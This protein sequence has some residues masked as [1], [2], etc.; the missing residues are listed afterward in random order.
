MRVATATE[1]K[2]NFGKILEDA[3]FEPVVIKRS[4]RASHVMLAHR[5]YERLKKIEDLYWIAKARE[6][7]ASGFIGKEAAAEILNGI[8]AQEDE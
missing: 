3:L 1:A 6:G 4:G 5:E 7:E 8:L 2:Q